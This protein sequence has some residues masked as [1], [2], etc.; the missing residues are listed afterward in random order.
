MNTTF[1]NYNWK[2]NLCQFTEILQIT[3]KLFMQ[4]QLQHQL[5]IQIPTKN[6]YA[7]D[8]ILQNRKSNNNVFLE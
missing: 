1:S 4:T 8:Y 2:H 3:I 5:T 7:P 6:V